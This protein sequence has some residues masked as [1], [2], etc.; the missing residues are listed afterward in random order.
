MNILV[1]GAGGMV[2]SHMVEFFHARKESVI[3]TYYKPTIDI[4]ELPP[5]IKMIECD[6]RYAPNIERII[7][8]YQPEQIYHLA[9]QSYPT[10]SWKHPYETMEINVNGTVAVFEAV[11]KVREFLN[12]DYD[13]MVVV[14]CSSAEYGDTFNHLYESEIYI[15]ETAELRPL[16][17]YGVSKVGQDLIAFQYFMNDHIRCIRARIFNSTGVRKTNDVTSDFTYRAVQ[18]EKQGVYEL[19]VGNLETSRAIMDQRDLVNAL[20]LLAEKG[21]SG[22]VYNISS[23]RI[24]QMQEIVKMIEKQIGHDLKIKVDSALLRPTDERIIVGDVTKLKRD[25]GWEQKVPMEQTIK[26]MLDYWR[27]KA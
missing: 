17:P 4:K 22:D 12:H 3:G 19:R 21:K 25:T 27:S 23:E 6:I 7:M 15:K 24:Y 26:D 5:E 1:T 2:G 16:H 9:A 20:V 10:V 11:K 18:A 8:E 13:P 14:A